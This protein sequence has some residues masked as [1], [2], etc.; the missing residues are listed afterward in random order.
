MSADRQKTREAKSL[1]PQQQAQRLQAAINNVN[2]DFPDL[3]EEIRANIV[4]IML[5]GPT[6]K[7]RPRR[8]SDDALGKMAKDMK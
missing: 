5:G 7:T 1:T 4:Q 3:S 6:G 8:S 2:A